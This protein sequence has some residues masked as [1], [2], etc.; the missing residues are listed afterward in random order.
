MLRQTKIPHCRLKFHILFCYSCSVIHPSQEEASGNNNEHN[1]QPPPDDLDPPQPGDSHTRGDDS[2]S[3]TTKPQS[4]PQCP[5]RPTVEEVIN[6][7]TQAPQGGNTNSDDQDLEDGYGFIFNR[8]TQTWEPPPEQRREFENRYGHNNPIPNINVPN[9]PG[10]H[11]CNPAQVHN[12][13]V[14]PDNV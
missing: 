14:R 5:P 8:R 1:H 10:P 11:R 13:P 3:D 7:D 4:P 6:N 2:K 9:E 12:T